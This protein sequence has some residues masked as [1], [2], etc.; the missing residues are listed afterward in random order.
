MNK[1]C[2]FSF[3]LLPTDKMSHTQINIYIYHP[4]MRHFRSSAG[5]GS[6]YKPDDFMTSPDTSDICFNF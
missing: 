4:V 2:C 5:P 3:G 1:I 6:S